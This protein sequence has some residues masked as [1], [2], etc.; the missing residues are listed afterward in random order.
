MLKI[1]LVR[2]GR[3]TEAALRKARW[4]RIGAQQKVPALLLLR[5]DKKIIFLARKQTRRKTQQTEGFLFPPPATPGAASVL[6][7]PERESLSREGEGE[8]QEQGW[9]WVSSSWGLVPGAR[10]PEGRRV[11]RRQPGRGLTGSV[12]CRFQ[13]ERGASEFGLGGEEG[14]GRQTDQFLVLNN[15]QRRWSDEGRRRPPPPPGPRRFL[16]KSLAGDRNRPQAACRPCS[17]AARPVVRQPSR[18]LPLPARRLPAGRAPP[19]AALHLTE[20]R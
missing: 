6:F 4:H 14:E 7:L 8:R 11:W 2:L 1:Y 20:G 10:E 5:K 3:E 13:T 19:S 12:C 15:F 16:A 18:A 17:L 9:S